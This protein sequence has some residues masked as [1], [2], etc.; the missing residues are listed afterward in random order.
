MAEPVQTAILTTGGIT[1]LG[2]ATGLHPALMLA[3]A[4]GGWWALSYQPTKTLLS[5]VN[6]ILLSSVIAAWS[7][8]VLAA[9]SYIPE[10][11]PTVPVQLLA[12]LLI[13]LAAMDVL[14]RGLLSIARRQIKGVGE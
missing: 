1:I 6:R 11:I 4:A 13:G 7:A 8:P 14:G 2:V 10:G 9:S 3:G 5:R 12:A